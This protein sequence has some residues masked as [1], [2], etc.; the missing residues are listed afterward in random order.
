[1]K[2]AGVPVPPPPPPGRIHALVLLAAAALAAACTGDD[3]PALADLPVWTAAEDLRVGAVDDSVYA[4]TWFRTLEVDGDGRMYTAHPR[5]QVIRVFDADGTLERVIGGRGDGP[6]E[7]QNLIV[8]GWVADTLWALDIDGYRFS[9]FG[10]DGDFL[11]S[12]QV[13]FEV[14]TRPGAS[15]PPR[16]TGLLFDGTVLGAPPA[17][18]RDVANG[19]LTHHTLMLL[20]RDG[21]VTDTL[22]PVA[23]GNSTWEITDPDNPQGGGSY[24]RQPFGDGSLW[25]RVPRERAFIH[26]DRT[27]PDSPEGAAVR[28]SRIDFDG[29][30]VFTRLLP[31]TPLP[32]DPA[33]VDSVLSSAAEM[34]ARAPMWD[35]SP[36]QARAWAEAGFYRPAYRPA[37]DRLVVARDGTLWLR[38][39]GRGDP[40]AWWVLNA[41]GEPVAEARLPASVQVSLIQG[42]W[43]WGME[44]DEMG[45]PYLVRLKLRT[46]T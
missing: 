31:Y 35:V 10:P 18:S 21:A 27:V 33:A 32:L 38:G 14:D 23:F 17:F 46:G 37:V 20:T 28:V 34:V 19:T 36:A 22:P 26:V 16:A 3:G 30:T 39:A 11:Y 15:Q 12:F 42:E 9:M 1:M 29:D 40:G 2:R 44:T 6:G 41:A 5:E 45:V 7:F 43:V 8:M 13:P 4:L 24:R 25:S